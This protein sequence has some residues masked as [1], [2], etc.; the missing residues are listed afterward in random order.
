[1][2]EKLTKDI[3]MNVLHTVI[4]P[5]LHISIVNLELIYEVK[6][7]DNEVLVIM[8]LT[9]P[10][11]PFAPQMIA[12]I[13]NKLEAAGFEKADVQV[14]FDPPWEP[15]DDVKMELGLI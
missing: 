5:E 1:M 8:T 14:T 4:D 7:K 6:I 13:K 2:T 11:C 3:A 10:L 15:S 12:E 9:S